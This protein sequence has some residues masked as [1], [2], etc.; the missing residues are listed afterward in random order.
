MLDAFQQSPQRTFDLR[1]KG[2][3]IW[4]SD[5]LIRLALAC[6][7]TIV[8]AAARLERNSNLAITLQAASEVQSPD[9]C[10]RQFISFF[11]EHMTNT[12]RGGAASYMT[13]S[14]R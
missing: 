2:G 4:I 10:R 8:F 5:S 14:V 12:A 1:A 6:K 3:S 13:V 7:A 9:D 11:E